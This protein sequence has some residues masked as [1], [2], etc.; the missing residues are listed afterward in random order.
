MKKFISWLKKH[1]VISISILIV[2]V[3]FVIPKIIDWV[4]F[5]YDGEAN[6]TFNSRDILNFWGTIVGGTIVL[7]G[8]FITIN[9]SNRKA[10]ESRKKH[11]KPKLS[12]A[13]KRIDDSSFIESNPDYTYISLMISNGKLQMIKGEAILYRFFENYTREIEGYPGK[14]FF[15]LE[16]QKTTICID[17]LIKN[18]G[19]EAACGIRFSINN[20]QILSEFSIPH[21]NTKTLKFIV[22]LPID[23]TSEHHIKLDIV[24]S[25]IDESIYY[26]AKEAFIICRD[27]NDFLQYKRNNDDFIKTE[28][29]TKEETNE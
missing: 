14:L 9:Q 16:K 26:V 23:D 29:T 28:E 13:L 5:C 20:S 18:D 6:T 2:L 1:K 27:S 10:E 25:N 19:S 3:V 15:E 21:N 8:V 11:I 17:Y 24:Y 7:I 4:Y 12:S 22:T